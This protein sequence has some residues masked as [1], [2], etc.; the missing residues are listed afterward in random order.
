MADAL[1][2]VRVGDPIQCILSCISCS[3][4]P[5]GFVIT[6]STDT[7]VDG[8]PIARLGD[9]TTNCCGCCCPCPNSIIGGSAKT[10][11]NGRPA[12]RKG[13]LVSG[14]FFLNASLTTFIG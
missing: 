8:L 6:G 4:C 14:G 12:A 9:T 10:F 13:D 3:P 2:A 1:R 7:I 5:N 11:I